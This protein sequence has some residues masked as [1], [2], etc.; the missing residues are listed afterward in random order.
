MTYDQSKV[1]ANQPEAEKQFNNNSSMGRLSDLYQMRIRLCDKKGVELGGDQ[2]VATVIDAEMTLE[3]QYSTP[4]EQSNPEHKLPT[5]MGMLQSGDWVE[6]VGSVLS[7]VFGVQ[8]S[9]NTKESLNKLEGRSNLTK[10]NSTQIFVSSQPVTIPA[11]LLFSAWED[12]KVEVEDQIKLLQQW[13]LPQSLA[14]GSL[15][16]E[17]AENKSLESLFPSVV[18]PYVALYYGKKRYF[19]MLISSCSA[20]LSVPMDND[21]NRMQLQVQVTFLSRTAWDAANINQLYT[22]V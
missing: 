10:T 20:P 11:T 12:A 3:S 17:V 4:F 9:E 1:T 16:N 21:G 6:T 18:P 2:V 13:A 19:P 8:L 7:N 22:G 14:E 5:L 15:I